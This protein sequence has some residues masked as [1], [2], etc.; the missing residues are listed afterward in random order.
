MEAKLQWGHALGAWKTACFPS[1]EIAGACESDFER[2]QKTSA[3]FLIPERDSS[4]VVAGLAVN[5]FERLRGFT[6]HWTARTAEKLIFFDRFA[7]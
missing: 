5:G 3:K 2:S 6:R 4:Q 1:F 7:K